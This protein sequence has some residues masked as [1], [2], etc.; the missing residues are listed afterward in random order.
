MKRTNKVRDDEVWGELEV[1]SA[2]GRC[3]RVRWSD[4]PMVWICPKERRRTLSKESVGDEGTRREEA[5]K[6][7]EKAK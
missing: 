2:G 6:T 4:G 1:R 3:R 7:H 5:R